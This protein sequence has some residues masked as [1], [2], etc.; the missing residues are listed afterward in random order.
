MADSSQLTLG[1]QQQEEDGA[2]SAASQSFANLPEQ[3]EFIERRFI[4]TVYE[5]VTL[6]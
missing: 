3:L 2:Y 4:K 1:A 6:H 5:Q